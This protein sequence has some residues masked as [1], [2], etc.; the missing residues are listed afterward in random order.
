MG[1]QDSQRLA[2]L[3]SAHPEAAGEFRHQS[4]AVSC[5]L[6]EI[7]ILSVE[8]MLFE[9]PEEAP[10]RAVVLPEPANA[11]LRSGAQRFVVGAVTSLLCGGLLLTLIPRTET[12]DATL[13]AKAE[14]L[15]GTFEANGGNVGALVGFPMAVDSPM[16]ADT[17][18]MKAA[19]GG[20]PNVLMG[21]AAIANSG[22]IDGSVSEN[23]SEPEVRPLIQSDDWNVVIVKI[24]GNDRDQAMDQIQ[25]I[26]LKAG[27]RLKGSSGHNESRWLG[28]VLASNVA[29]REDV[30][31]AMEGV[32]ASNGYAAE[33]PQADSQEAMFIAAARES[34]KYPTRSELH[35]GKVFVVLPSS[36]SMIGAEQIVAASEKAASGNSDLTSPKQAEVPAAAVEASS[37]RSARVGA[38]TASAVTLVVF[39][40]TDGEKS[41]PNNSEQ[42]I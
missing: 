7:P 19:A 6:K 1:I 4:L 23:P 9:F 24:E 14:V 34:L 10:P 29:G 42:Q 39:E 8:G 17:G 26:V 16:V 22:G 20:P 11:H 33:T 40:F 37:A 5:L 32:G 31:N 21:S 27:L 12:N 2:A 25:A 28:V 3:A 30:V 18:Q 15:H 36:A 35:H 41:G 38:Q 13:S